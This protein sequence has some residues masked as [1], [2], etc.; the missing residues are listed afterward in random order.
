[1]FD[2]QWLLIAI[3]LAGAA[4]LLTWGKEADGFGHLIGTVASAAS[5]VL[6]V[7][8]FAQLLGKPEDDR[9]HTT[10]LFTW[11]DAGRFHVDMSFTF[12]Q[13]S[14]LFVLLITG[15]GTLIHIYSIGYMEHDERRRRFFA[16]L[17]LFIA[18][19]LTLVLAA[20]YLVM[21]L[22]WEG[23]GLAS[24]LLIG[25]WQHKDSAAAAAKKAFVV[26][27]VG[28]LGM[29]L[30][31]MLMF[32]QFG[33]SAIEA[34]NES[35]PGATQNVATA[36]GLL[37]LLGACGKSAQVPLQS[38]LL[39]A[40]EG[41]TPVS[42]LIHAAT[43][44]TAGVYLIVRSAAIFDASEAA[45]TAV[46]V[47]GLV[48]LLA[49]AWIGCTK[50]DIKKALAGS[51][52]SQIGYMMLAAGLGPAGYAFAI[53][54]LIT[55]GF[56]KAN[57][58]LGAGSVMHGMN[59]DVDMRH[60]GAV[61]KAMPFT[62]ATFAIGYLAIIGFPGFSGFFSKDKIIEAAF[63]HNVWV[64][65][66][67]LLGAGVTAFYMTRLMMMTFFG[68]KRWQ[69][70][71]HPHES[72]KVMTVPLIALAALSVLGGALAIG[73]WIGDWLAPVVGE[74]HHEELPIPAIAIT[75]LVGAVVAVGVA[76]G[77]FLYGTRPIAG[78]TPADASVSAWT[79]AGRHELYGN[80][81]NDA[82][83]VRPTRHL[84]RFLVWFDRMGV[85][86]LV[87]GI[88]D[89]LGDTSQFLRQPQTGYVRSYALMMFGG[90]ALVLLALLAVTLA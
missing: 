33:T 1:M 80:E 16:F 82:V 66:G 65:L 28:D 14:G 15:V 60:Y 57:L 24:Y 62:F 12:D 2:L 90:A 26:N 73:G 42:A 8:L 44:V 78:E 69:E 89:R 46:I 50:D 88:A 25:F 32:A 85:D 48:T 52:M 23:V 53:F 74:A 43:M 61:R 29:A 54:H 56:F 84:T 63:G 34:V 11:I 47:V 59:D 38:W 19:M 7:I 77:Y 83:A 55:H 35:I 45:R 27:R 41:P 64:G 40:M 4:I 5:F 76:L 20:D 18:A 70:D 22:G 49:G 81:I 37:L 17:N 87:T 79:K 9:S 36:M 10:T 13:L 39:D 72:P 51:T 68:E 71:V 6:G 86:G 58:F 31:I 67:T 3:P 21:F 75:L 30:A